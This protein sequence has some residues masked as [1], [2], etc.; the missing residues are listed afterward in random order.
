M[1]PFGKNRNVS[2]NLRAQS[3]QI[4]PR[5]DTHASDQH[6]VETN[7][8][9]RSQRFML[10][11]WRG[12][13]LLVL[14]FGAQRASA[15]SVWSMGYYYPQS[16]G[17]LPALSS[18]DW[19]ALTHVF[20][21]GGQPNGNGTLTLTGN[22]ASL[23]TALVSAAHAHGVKVIFSLTSVGGRTNFSGAVST[24]ESTFVANI[25]SLVN[26]YGFDGVDVDNEE[27]WNSNLMTTLLSDLRTQ[28]G[29]KIL[30]ATADDAQTGWAG[31][32]PVCDSP[33]AGWDAGHASY[34]DRLSLM[35]YDIG[36]PGNGDPYT[37]HNSPLFSVKGQYLWSADYLVKAFENCGIPA[38]KLNIG[39]PF[40]GDLYT[41]NSQPYQPTGSGATA[42]QVGYNALV[43]RYNTSGVTYDSTAHVPWM[44]VSSSSYLS[45][46]NPQSITD[47]VNYVQTNG[48][49]GWIIWVL[50]WDYLP[51]NSP[52]DPLLDAI[53]KAFAR[54]QAPTAV[55]ISVN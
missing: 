46:E 37:W 25:M 26:T 41:A 10:A 3:Q 52:Q 40:Y 38:S 30:T 18:I 44:T 13:L 20:M 17:G 4:E 19:T 54:P 14:T 53:G 50:G 36:N 48:L 8:A 5:N 45:W 21:V 31:P 35:N 22:F 55:H 15:Q 12:L 34:L 32:V 49:G 51:G 1:R 43:A 39:I 33:G 11:V 9:D 6:Y 47:K 42:T 28:L 27:Q 2:H 7:V 16:T 29:S 23:A 24:S